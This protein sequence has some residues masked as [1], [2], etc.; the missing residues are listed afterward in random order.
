M[1]VLTS[2]GDCPGMNVGIRAV[3][4]KACHQGLKVVGI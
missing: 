1:A 2:G 3:V 4:R